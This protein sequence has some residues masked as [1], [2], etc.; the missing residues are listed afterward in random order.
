MVHGAWCMVHGAWCM[1][2]GAWCMVHGAWC[3]VHVA[4]CIVCVAW[5][6]VHDENGPEGGRGQKGN[7]EMVSRHLQKI[8]KEGDTDLIKREELSLVKQFLVDTME[9]VFIDDANIEGQAQLQLVMPLMSNTSLISYESPLAKLSLAI[10]VQLQLGEKLSESI[11][12]LRRPLVLHH[13]WYEGV[14]CH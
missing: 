14:L 6:V 7:K 1:V 2:H 4:W 5:R 12:S 13:Q 3:M 9:Q 10:R 11:D 8:R